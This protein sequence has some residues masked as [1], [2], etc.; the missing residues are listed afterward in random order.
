MGLLLSV[1]AF[2][3]PAMAQELGIDCDLIDYRIWTGDNVQGLHYLGRPT[4]LCPDGTRIRAD[5]AVIYDAINR[6]EMIG[7]VEFDHPERSL[8]AAYA[9]YY[10]FEAR[11]FARGNVHFRDLVRGSEV[12]GDTLTWLEG[13]TVRLEEEMHVRGTPAVALLVPSGDDP[14]P[15]EPYRVTAERIRSQ[16]N[17]FFWASGGT[18][19]DRDGLHAA[20][21][22][23]VFDEQVGSMVLLGS[24]RATREE[25]DMEGDRINLLLPGDRI[26]SVD[27]TGRARLTTTDI[28]VTGDEVR[29]QLEEERV[30]RLVAVFR[31]PAPDPAGVEGVDPE[32]GA[33]PAGERPSTPVSLPRLIAEDLLVTGDSIDV[34]APGEVLQTVAAAGRGRIETGPG[35][36]STG[37]AEGDPVD[38]EGLSESE[39][40]L[41]SLPVHDWIEGD[42]IVATFVPAPAGDDRE[43]APQEAEATEAGPQY[44]L[45]RLHA[46]GNARSW[47]R[48]P[49][50]DEGPPPEDRHRW[51]ISYV[52]AR[53]ILVHFDGGEVSW[54]EATGG[55]SGWQAEPERAAGSTG[56]GTTED[57]E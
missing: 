53:E 32:T 1:G 49:P 52:L 46:A 19:I 57:R 18:E 11:L 25:L 4:L 51:A 21:D 28:E 37:P 42:L 7:S 22:S 45:E 8:R 13:G 41:R 5:S 27:I 47:Y 16:G 39:A 10:E 34:E 33:L 6:T 29:L 44:R 54:I 36:G 31:A 14:S 48:Q 12:F 2:A 38:T 24:A 50:E 35:A 40:L 20:S 15:S 55:V 26:E 17:R 43:I 3:A 9:D 30:E 23:L 56:P